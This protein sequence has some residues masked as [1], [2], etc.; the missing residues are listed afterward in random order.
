MDDRRSCPGEEHLSPV[1]DSKP[2][3]GQNRR[4]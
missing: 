3:P 4:R 2:R 1:D